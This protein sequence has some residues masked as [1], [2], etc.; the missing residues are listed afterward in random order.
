MSYV[1]LKYANGLEIIWRRYWASKDIQYETYECA[2]DAQFRDYVYKGYLNI[3]NIV[4]D[5]T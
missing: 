4:F 1:N 5:K 3:Q 2:N